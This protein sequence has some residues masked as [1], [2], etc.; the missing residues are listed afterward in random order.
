MLITFCINNS[1]NNQNLRTRQQK[2]TTQRHLLLLSPSLSFPLTSSSLLQPAHVTP[3]PP[4][5]TCHAP[6]R[7]S[8][9][10]G[11]RNSCSLASISSPSR[12]RGCL[13]LLLD[14]V[15]CGIA[16]NFCLLSVYVCGWRKGRLGNGEWHGL[17]TEKISKISIGFLKK[18]S[19]HYKY[20]WSIFGTSVTFVCSL[21]LYEF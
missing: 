2:R 5:A 20:F 10:S 13:L 3:P 7:G 17:H 6:C 14:A 8:P 18:L 4:P 12:L 11:P 1:S 15:I 16:I 9:I 21:Y 19:G